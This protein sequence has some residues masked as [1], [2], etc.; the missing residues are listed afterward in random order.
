M[1]QMKHAEH[2][3]ERWPIWPQFQQ[4][5]HEAAVWS[6]EPQIQHGDIMSQRASAL[7]L[8][9]AESM[10]DKINGYGTRVWTPSKHA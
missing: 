5:S 7:Q 10:L 1:P 3:V 9:A 4:H 8:N 6:R 2:A